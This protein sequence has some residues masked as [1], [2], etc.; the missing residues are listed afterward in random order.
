MSTAASVTS[1]TTIA[2]SHNR[3]PNS[4]TDRPA[5][6]VNEFVYGPR[7]FFTNESRAC[8]ARVPRCSPHE[9]SEAARYT[10]EF[11]TGVY[12]NERQ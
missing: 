2:G 7:L 1:P 5:R 6:M 8:S 4:L 12:R 3:A 11:L 9:V 10:L